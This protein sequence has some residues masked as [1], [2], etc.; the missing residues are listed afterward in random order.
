MAKKLLLRLTKI[1]KASYL[2][3][4]IRIVRENHL[5]VAGWMLNNWM[6]T[7][8]NIERMVL[9]RCGKKAVAVGI[10][11]KKQEYHGYPNT[12]IFVKPSHRRQGIGTKILKQLSKTKIPLK[13]AY[14]TTPSINFYDKYKKD[15]NL[16]ILY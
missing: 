15:L 9:C 7:P 11:L 8:S 5:F 13:V 4:A 3:R 10:V 14:G 2:S 16:H 12:G 6:D 1:K